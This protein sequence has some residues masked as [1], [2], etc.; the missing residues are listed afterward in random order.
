MKKIGKYE[1]LGL[2]GRGGMGAVYKAAMPVT[3]KIVAL[4]LLKPTQFLKTLVGA[5]EI[6]RQFLSEAHLLGGLNHRHVASVWDF[7][8]A[9]RRPY[10][11]MEYYCRDL[12]QVI[13]ETARVEA[14]TRRLPLPRAA[15]YAAQTLSGLARLHHAGIVHRD[16]KP[17]N[18]LITDGDQ[19]KIT[20]LGL[21]KVRGESLAGRPG[22]KVGSPYYAAPEQEEDPASAGPRAD[23]YSVA[24]T[25]YR[26]IAGKLP[27]WPLAGA[28]LPSALSRDLDGAWDDFFER[29]LSPDPARRHRDAREMEAEIAVLLA[30]WK[31]R[32]ER[33]CSL[34]EFAED[35]AAC[36]PDGKPGA[37]RG[38]PVKT[39]VKHARRM[40]DLDELW[41]PRCYRSP[42]L[43]AG[44][45]VVTDETSGL[46]WQIGGSPYPLTWWE[47]HEYV[48]GL[49]A[50][51]LAGARNWRLP[52][53]DELAG[54]LTPPPEF[55]GHCLSPVFDTRQRLLWSADR[56]AYTQGWFADAELGAFAWADM[57][58]R[59]SVRAVRTA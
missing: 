42:V 54:I 11:V 30:D 9:G 52:T 1:I 20:D 19:I 59:R 25:F 23:L 22:L 27:D 5:K 46:V 10:F 29:A 6:E 38:E 57:T 56:R 43:T 24:V 51:G 2:L 34:E 45:G 44:V 35:P 21:S 4:K 50:S 3:G 58:C 13:G 18:L 8:R 33:A 14:P 53:V 26:M 7:G 17:F 48:A 36:P 55:T 31:K 49:N 41:R 28:S 39:P 15:G 32:L 40:L 16:V 47:A 12:G 37:V